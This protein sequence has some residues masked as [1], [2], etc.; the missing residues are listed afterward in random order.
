MLTKF[1]EVFLSALV[2]PSRS[3]SSVCEGDFPRI[4]ANMVCH[5]AA[6]PALVPCNG[7]PRNTTPQVATSNFRC[8]LL[9][10]FAISSALNSIQFALNQAGDDRWL[11]LVST[12]PPKHEATKINGLECASCCIGNQDMHKLDN[13][14]STL[15]RWLWRL[16]NNTS[17]TSSIRA[18][19]ASV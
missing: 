14:G 13:M 10:I 18:T 2:L 1:S 15:S 3:S 12:R 7:D 8:S 16:L 6:S 11:T 17:A 19:E 9:W 5:W 4:P